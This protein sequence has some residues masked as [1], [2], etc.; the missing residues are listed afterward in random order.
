MQKQQA[1]YPIYPI[2]SVNFVGTLGFSIVLPFLIFL[3][4]RFGGNAFIYGL[5][6]A[7]YS[8][9]QF[10]GAP[11]L[12][13]WSDR[14][15][16]RK[17]LLLSHLGTLFSWLI[18]LVAL[19]TPVEPLAEIDWPLAGA[20]T[21]TL[22]LLIL[23]AARALDGITG[24]NISVAN[25]YLA[26]I[27]PDEQHNANFGKMAVSANLGFVV[28]PA[29]AGLLGTTA[30]GEV[31]PVL[32]AIAI[33]VV[34]AL[35]IIFALKEPEHCELDSDPLPG[36][37]RKLLGQELK[38]CFQPTGSEPVGFREI[39]G[40]A[41][42]RRLLAIYF[43]VFLGFNFFYIAF[44]VYAVKELHWQLSDTG[45]FFSFFGLAMGSVQGPLLSRL[46][47]KYEE[48]K[49]IVAGNVILIGGFLLF[50]STATIIMY[51]AA[52]LISLGNGIMWPSV[53]ALLSKSAK[54]EYQGAVQGLAG[55]LGSL[56]SIIGLIVGGILY[57]WLAGHIFI[58]SSAIML[59]V[60][61][62]SLALRK[63]TVDGS[64]VNQ[65]P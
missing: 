8:F 61:F 14:S 55:S 22:P 30:W 7:T 36:G 26:D 47:K 16:R 12:G 10:I 9:F 20:F 27:T 11:L 57:E 32:A 5:T 1:T 44:P 52:L 4:T 43:F 60:F 2:L 17:I 25:A 24:G 13:R 48:S 51:A 63:I 3:V 50:T 41:P 58:L 45:L 40:M 59:L 54:K 65:I 21:L 56:A 28:G 6:G 62:L 29:I 19:Y 53:M 33:S 15:G 39:L 37:V 42:V 49:L 64:A 38:D 46:S 23:F 34:A 35:L 31:P 18:F